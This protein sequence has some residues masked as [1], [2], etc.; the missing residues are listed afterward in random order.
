M[1]VRHTIMWSLI[2]RLVCEAPWLKSWFSDF[3]CNVVLPHARLIG[4][5]NEAEILI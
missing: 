3:F 2:N 1:V 4:N 5:L